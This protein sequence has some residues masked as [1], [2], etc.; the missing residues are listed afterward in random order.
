MFIDEAVLDWNFYYEDGSGLSYEDE[1]RVV[2]RAHDI[3][4]HASEQVTL[5]CTEFDCVDAI[6]G[7]K[8]AIN[9]RLKAI[10][11]AYCFDS[12]P[13]SSSKRTLEKF[14]FYGIIRPALLKEIFE[15]RNSIEHKDTPPPGA[16]QCSR[17]ID[18]TWYFLKSTDALLLMH[19]DN[20]IFWAD[21]SKGEL[22][23]EPK[24][25]GAWEITV[26]GNLPQ[27]KI[28]NIPRSGALE[29]DEH[30]ERPTYIKTPIWGLWKPDPAQ[31]SKFARKYFQL[32]GYWW[33]DHA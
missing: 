23:F 20:V 8:R 33:Q 30:H 17:F 5:G 7:L 19:P 2:D 9:L 13:F 3:W 18:F 15:I 24:F 28:L 32:S 22:C 4:R 11:E 10:S 29:I 31:L 21:E 12:L 27:E 6:T 14:Q 26:R 1:V 25:K 16:E